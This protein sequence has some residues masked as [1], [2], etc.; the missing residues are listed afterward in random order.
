MRVRM[1]WKK[2]LVG[3]GLVSIFA[4]SLLFIMNALT[5]QHRQ[6]QFS[7]Q[8][9]HPNLS[10]TDTSSYSLRT[11]FQYDIGSQ[12]LTMFG[13]LNNLA[14]EANMMYF[15]QDF[16]GEDVGMTYVIFTFSTAGWNLDELTTLILN[17]E[18]MACGPSTIIADFQSVK[19]F[20][21]YQDSTWIQIHSVNASNFEKIDRAYG[22]G[23]YTIP[24]PFEDYIISDQIQLRFEYQTQLTAPANWDH[25]FYFWMLVLEYQQNAAVTT[26]PPKQITLLSP[27]TTTTGGLLALYTVEGYYY[28]ITKSIVPGSSGTLQFVVEYDLSHYGVDLLLGILFEHLDFI[29]IDSGSGFV[30]IFIVGESSN[31]FLAYSRDHTWMTNPDIVPDDRRGTFFALGDFDVN[32]SIHL[33]YD[34]HYTNFG[35]SVV[36]VAIDLAQLSVVRDANPIIVSD[37][38]DPIIYAGNSVQLNMTCLDGRAPI[39]Q[40]TVEPWGD[41]IGMGEG[42]YTY[43][44]LI[45]TADDQ[46]I[47]IIVED[48]AGHVYNHSLGIVTVLPRPI[49]ISLYLTENAYEQEFAFYF[50]MADLFSG[51]PLAL[52]P[53]TKTILK[54]GILFRQQDHQTTPTGEFYLEEGV[55][56]YLDQ[57]YT[58]IIST[59]DTPVYGATQVQASIILSDT[60]PFIT[61]D[62]VTHANPLKANTLISLDYTT[63]S[64][65]S[66]DTLWLYRNDTSYLQITP[67][68]LGSY[69]FSF[70]DE[71]GYWKYYFR[72]TSTRGHVGYSNPLNLNISALETTIQCDSNLN[73]DDHVISL[74]IDLVDELSRNCAGVPLQ[75]VIYDFDEVFYEQSLV[76]GIGGVI[77]FIHFDRFLDHAFSIQI[78]SAATPLYEGA[79]LVTQS[80]MA[81]EGFPL[82]TILLSSVVAGVISFL[83]LVI[84]RRLKSQPNLGGNR[85]V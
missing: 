19:V 31:L 45:P 7:A 29:D 57:N 20:I 79:S 30:Q 54:N 26:L 58:V 60:T 63:N 5:I 62:G 21:K 23:D 78:T 55:I 28:E 16:L 44:R 50:T 74:D 42:F 4:I 9:Q 65:G 53:F 38:Q 46:N 75:V 83:L 25:L 67:A 39:T 22:W 81:F 80:E 70:V 51:S 47:S 17:W 48:A 10:K 61:I 76:T 59:T 27:N 24:M 2:R 8:T 72:G 37:L 40:I 85:N 12:T 32:R 35:S 14:Q 64:Q 11:P 34:V 43:S 66:L 77:L 33:L 1:S 84:K 3:I 18:I 41:F 82:Y 69:N 71:S 49:A 13:D 73:M 15:W 6:S 52:F 36:K 68:D 56:D